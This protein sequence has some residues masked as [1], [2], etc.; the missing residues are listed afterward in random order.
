LKHD[1]ERNAAAYLAGLLSGARRRMFERHMVEC[2]DCWREVD[3]GRKGRSVAESGRELA[4]QSLRERVRAA[5][6]TMTPSPRRPRWVLGTG[7]IM[8]VA[9]AVAT[10]VLAIP[11]Q[12]REIEAVLASFGSGRPMGTLSEPEL[13][14]RLA[15]LRLDR[16]EEGELAGLE[17]VAH[18]YLDPSGDEVVV[19]VTDK[20]WP[21]ALGAERDHAGEMWT[22]RGDELVMICL[23]DPVPSLVVGDD[24]HDVQSAAYSLRP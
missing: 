5:V 8:L 24:F 23:N 1:P 11:R 16:A 19:Y 6:E 20:Q 18:H 10:V 13:P 15:N 9:A 2:E 21:V 4:P 3:L 7:A 14:E 22:A 17:V 12:P